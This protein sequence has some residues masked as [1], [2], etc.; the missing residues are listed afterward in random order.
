MFIADPLCISWTIW[1]ENNQIAFEDK[2][3]ND[4][5]LKLLFFVIFLLGLSCMEEKV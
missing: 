4:K 1:R 2:E 3:Q 5:K